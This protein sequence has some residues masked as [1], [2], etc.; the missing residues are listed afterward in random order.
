MRLPPPL[1]RALNQLI[2]NE[3]T[4]SKKVFRDSDPR[5]RAWRQLKKTL[6]TDPFYNAFLEFLVEGMLDD[7]LK[8]EVHKRVDQAR[9][10]YVPKGDGEY[11][12]DVPVITCSDTRHPV[13]IK[14][15]GPGGKPTPKLM[16]EAG[17]RDHI[18]IAE[19]REQQGLLLLRKSRWHK[20][21]V[22]WADRHGLS[23]HIVQ[24][25]FEIEPDE[26]GDGDKAN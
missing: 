24:E 25:L 10:Q 2:D 1:R 14:P 12:D 8:G 16:T 6:Q 20:D 13:W 3:L 9:Q 11:S 22:D 7:F 21:V 18:R 5:N 15:P 4:R 26:N 23:E 19:R 17:D